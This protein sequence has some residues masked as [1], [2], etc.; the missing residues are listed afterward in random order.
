MGAARTPNA[1]YIA[2]MVMLGFH[3]Y[4]GLWSTCQT[5][6]I[7]NPKIRALRRPVSAAIA[8]IVVVGNVS[9]PLSILTGIVR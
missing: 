7:N 6:D 1:L 8:V 3:M 2:A 5:L 9:I 4:H